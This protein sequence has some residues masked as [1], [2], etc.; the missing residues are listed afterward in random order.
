MATVRL[1][2]VCVTVVACVA[3]AS[4]AYVDRQRVETEAFYDQLDDLFPH[5]EMPDA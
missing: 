5:E 1:L 3:I 2:I 4:A